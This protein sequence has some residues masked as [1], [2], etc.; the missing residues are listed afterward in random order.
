MIFLFLSSIVPLY[1]LALLLN[2]LPLTG[3]ILAATFCW[4]LSY[5]FPVTTLGYILAAEGLTFLTSAVFDKTLFYEGL[6]IIMALNGYRHSRTTNNLTNQRSP[7]IFLVAYFLLM[8]QSDL[9]NTLT[10]AIPTTAY[11]AALTLALGPLQIKTKTDFNFIFC[12]IGL[13][14]LFVSVWAISVGGS[15]FRE[16]AKLGVINY[17]Y[18]DANVTSHAIGLGLLVVTFAV[19][20]SRRILTTV[21]LATLLPVCLVALTIPV[22]RG[23][24]VSLI[25][26]TFAY[27]YARYNLTK[28]TLISAMLFG[29]TIWLFLVSPIGLVF[30]KRFSEADV[31]T[32]NGR[33]VLQ[34]A[35]LLGLSRSNA[36][37]LLFGHG[38]GSAM[39]AIGE[40]IGFGSRTQY[41]HSSYLQIS[42][43]IGMF[44]LAIIL[45]ILIYSYIRNN[46][47][48]SAESP[49]QCGFLIFIAVMGLQLGP[50]QLPFCVVPLT[51]AF[52]YF[53]DPSPKRKPP[54]S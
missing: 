7:L 28:K 37:E 24:F 47:S 21:I 30:L 6:S 40:V 16:H 33:T 4:I 9:H 23:A 22:S 1:A 39:H 26:A 25:A 42:Y 50:I 3:Y 53:S 54:R 52:R 27:I 51:L 34:A 45:A 8:I 14:G 13:F 12:V 18:N 2:P 36:L 41:P 38:S 11:F 20:Q 15:Y 17:G 43:E 48:K 19:I 31:A 44:G 49:I 35:I 5:K 29:L 46:R 32:G 10:G